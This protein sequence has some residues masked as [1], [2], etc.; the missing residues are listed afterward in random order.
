MR[1]MILR[2]QRSER[3]HRAALKAMLEEHR[4]GMAEIKRE[5]REMQAELRDHRGEWREAHEEWRE[6]HGESREAFSEMIAEQRAGRLALLAILDRLP[7][8][9]APA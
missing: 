8:G 4:S 6:A 9:S 5:L 1:E 3:E 7:P 2:M